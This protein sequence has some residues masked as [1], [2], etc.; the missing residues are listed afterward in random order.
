MPTDLLE[1]ALASGDGDAPRGVLADALIAAGDPFG[2][3]IALQLRQA[4]AGPELARETA[5]RLRVLSRELEPELRNRFWPAEGQLRFHRGL[6]ALLATT[7]EELLRLPVPRSLVRLEL[8]RITPELVP[9][10]AQRLASIRVEGLSLG[11]AGADWSRASLA[12]LLEL[13]LKV[14][15]LTIDAG[16]ATAA[17]AASRLVR[18]V[19]RVELRGNLDH[20]ELTL[21]ALPALDELRLDTPLTLERGVRIPP[22]LTAALDRHRDVVVPAH[23]VEAAMPIPVR[24]ATGRWTSLQY[25]G[26]RDEF[27][28]SRVIDPS[29]QREGI[30][31]RLRS[32]DDLLPDTRVPD[33]RERSLGPIECGVDANGAWCV[34]A[35]TTGRRWN[36]I[37]IAQALG[38]SGA[39][40][41]GALA[42][43]ARLTVSEQLNRPIPMKS[44]FLGPAGIEV[45]W[46]SPVLDP[47]LQGMFGHA[48]ENAIT[49]LREGDH[50]LGLTWTLATQL[51]MA[52]GRAGLH[53]R[54]EGYV[55]PPD[56]NLPPG[57][58]TLIRRCLAREPAAR[59]SMPEV[60]RALEAYETPEMT[61]E[62]AALD[63]P[64]PH[65]RAE[66]QFDQPLGGTRLE[67]LRA[68]GLIR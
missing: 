5:T 2:E 64:P 3:F 46:P 36:N 40:L 15:D 57:L 41:A 42:P 28:A 16:S 55:N 38:L 45:Q 47:F 26:S 66:A 54:P 68:R 13:E 62:L 25:L 31:A 48:M 67:T 9:P 49:D 44:L 51:T 27:A 29:T 18:S 23:G 24:A 12:P 8:T 35:L 39:T 11:F 59:P 4:E 7:A 37:I 52:L 56:L 22:H 63:V 53:T 19:R 14:T 58:R 17:L 10:V 21:N 6:P 30:L 60:A 43:V 34:Y 32:D 50:E 61:K 33:S 20:P 65:E 1:A